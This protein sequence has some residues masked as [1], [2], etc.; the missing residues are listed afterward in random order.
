MRRALILALIVAGA[1]V[2]SAAAVFSHQG[3]RAGRPLKGEEVELVTLKGT[4]TDAKRPMI[5]IEADGKEYIL[6]LGPIRFWQEKGHTFE[7][8]QAVEVTGAVEEFEGILHSYPHTIKINGESIEL[9][10][11]DGVPVW[12]GSGFGRDSDHCGYGPGYGG[13]GRGHM[14]GG[15]GY[16]HGYMHGRGRY[17]RGHM[18]GR[19]WHGRGFYGCDR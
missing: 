1:M 14:M 2:I 18:S 17:G 15:G 13:H 10:D 16:G 19:G 8:G 3:W 9:V 11:E 6:H 5:T 12:A 7:K 4:V